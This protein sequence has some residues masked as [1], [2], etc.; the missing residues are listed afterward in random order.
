MNM[1]LTRKLC[2]HKINVRLEAMIR[3]LYEKLAITFI[4]V[5]S[6]VFLAIA[7]IITITGS[8]IMVLVPMILILWLY[9]IFMP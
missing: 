8:A 2:G 4:I 7:T 6:P 5:L 1:R 3:R 9:G